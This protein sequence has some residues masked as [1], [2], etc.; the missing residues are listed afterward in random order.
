MR[1]DISGWTTRL[2]EEDIVR[3]TRSGAWR[4]ATLADC[5]RGLA[6]HSPERTAAVEGTRT[7]TFAELYA[8]AQR[9]AG[10]FH[11]LGLRPGAVISL[12]LPNWI[13]T[14]AINLAACMAG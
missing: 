12:Q 13:E 1:A 7:V 3:Y 11:A 6:Q 2:S 9:L 8:Q 5:A 14:L 4:N 10:A